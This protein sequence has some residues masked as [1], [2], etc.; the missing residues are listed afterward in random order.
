MAHPKRKENVDLIVKTL[1]NKNVKINV[2]Y[3]DVGCIWYNHRK[4]WELIDDID[5]YDYH[6]VIQDDAIISKDF[7]KNMYDELEKGYDVY[8]RYC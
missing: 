7:I 2:S 4:S 5:R 1:K 6:T 3:D 8:N